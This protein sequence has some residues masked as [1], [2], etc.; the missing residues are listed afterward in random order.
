M[1]AWMPARPCLAERG[2]E[3]PLEGGSEGTTAGL[4]WTHTYMTAGLLP[5]PSR[6]R[7]E[8]SGSRTSCLLSRSNIPRSRGCKSGTKGRTWTRCKSGTKGTTW[9]RCKSGT[10]VR[11]LDEVQAVQ[12]YDVDEVQAVQRFTRHSW[13]MEHFTLPTVVTAPRPVCH[14]GEIFSI[15]DCRCAAR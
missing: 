7:L 10:K 2:A 4:N 1:S 11:C 6:R 15:R 13:H 12:K 5:L 9:T 8:G 3:A 14:P